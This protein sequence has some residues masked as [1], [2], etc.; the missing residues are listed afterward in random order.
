L[1]AVL[2]VVTRAAAVG[3]RV[4]SVCV[5]VMFCISRSGIIG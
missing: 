5:G 4:R 1:S 2:S 3:A